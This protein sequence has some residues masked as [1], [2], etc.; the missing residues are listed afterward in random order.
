MT[1]P[2]SGPLPPDFSLPNGR[3]VILFDGVCN[4]CN[5]WVGFVLDNDPDGLF[6]FASLQVTFFR[7]VSLCET[8]AVS[9][10]ALSLLTPVPT[11]V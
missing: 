6:C 3:S 5:A 7:G 9:V 2:L 11:A 4:F 10:P 1:G 8:R